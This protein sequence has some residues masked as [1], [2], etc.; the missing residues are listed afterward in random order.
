MSFFEYTSVMV[1][2]ILALGISRILGGL[3]QLLAKGESLRPYWVHS[4][5]LLFYF[6]FHVR[7]WWAYW[8]L[9]ET[10]PTNLLIFLFMLVSPALGYLGT[11]VLL[12][13]GYPEDADDHFYKVRR[14]F[15]V[16]GLLAIVTA[17]ASPVILGYSVP[18]AYFVGN[19]FG[20][21]VAALGLLSRSRRVQGFVALASV[22]GF[23]ASLL[24]RMTAGAFTPR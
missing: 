7:V 6:L 10:P 9:R 15:F 4:L 2:V 1:S 11:Y 21:G 14:P 22:V 19:G 17:S 24:M 20:F 23:S 5:W 13:G 16:V 8:D 3:G 12:P 18:A